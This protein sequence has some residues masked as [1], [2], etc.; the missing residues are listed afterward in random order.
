MFYM[1]KPV[2]TS[3]HFKEQVFG[4]CIGFLVK[5]EIKVIRGKPSQMH[6]Q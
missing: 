6:V 3:E 4:F 2:I 1:L 5:L